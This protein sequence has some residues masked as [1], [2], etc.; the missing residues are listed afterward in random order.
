[1][2]VGCQLQLLGL[3]QLAVNVGRFE[4]DG[5]EHI[6]WATCDGQVLT[7]TAPSFLTAV[8]LALQWVSESCGARIWGCG[9]D[10]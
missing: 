6:W 2:S 5:F 3:R 7:K 1:V 10:L 4:E 8:D 9:F